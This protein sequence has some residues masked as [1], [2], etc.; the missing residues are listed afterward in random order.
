MPLLNS[1]ASSSIRQPGEAPAPFF[2]SL[3]L[4]ILQPKRHFLQT[5][6]ADL[7]QFSI[8]PVLH[9]H[10]NICV[11]AKHL[12]HSEHYVCRALELQALISVWCMYAAPKTINTC[13]SLWLYTVVDLRWRRGRST[14]GGLSGNGYTLHRTEF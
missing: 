14:G 6:T 5:E 11:Q 13:D 3:S 7:P 4:L 8:S 10:W 12:G 1:S 9:I 2:S